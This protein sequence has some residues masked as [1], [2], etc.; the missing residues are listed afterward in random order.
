MALLFRNTEWC[1]KGRSQERERHWIQETEG[2]TYKQGEKNSQDF[3]DGK[4]Q[5]DSWAVGLVSDQYS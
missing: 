4:F 3:S 5:D 1:E 2:V